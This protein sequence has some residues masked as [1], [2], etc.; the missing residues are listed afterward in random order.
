MII[1][2]SDFYELYKRFDDIR[3]LGWIKSLRNGPTGVG[4]T[5]ECLLNKK[6]DN[7]QQ[8]DF[9][10]IEIKTIKYFSKR[11]IHLFNAT[12]EYV[13]FSPIKR[14]LQKYGYPDKNYPE[15][16]LFNISVNAVEEKRVGYNLLK[17]NVDWDHR[18]IFLCARTIY[19]KKNDL[20]IYWSF[21]YLDNIIKNKLA[22]LAI[23]WAC[24]K[25]EN[26]CDMFLYAK[27]DFYKYTNIDNFIKLIEDG[28][29]NI[30][31]KISFYKS[32]ERSGMIHDK[33]TDFSIYEKDIKL[34]FNKIS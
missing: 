17:L 3:K 32:E 23:V 15:Y 16:K 26:A 20:N 8:P 5:F 25:K 24:Y 4:Y 7:L 29:I 1:L 27:I 10:S 21:D 30:T 14:I 9:K 11:K 28:L 31:F 13:F 34:L 33:G 18:K 22:N 2:N 19:N 12:P 6:E